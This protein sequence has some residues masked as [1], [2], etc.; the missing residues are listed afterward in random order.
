V[1]VSN[2]ANNNFQV[3][4]VTPSFITSTTENFTVGTECA[5]TFGKPVDSTVTIKATPL[6]T[7]T[8]T[9]S[10]TDSSTEVPETAETVTITKDCYG[11]CDTP[12]NPAMFMVPA[13]RTIDSVLIECSVE[14]KATG[15]VVEA[16]DK[17]IAFTKRKASNKY[18]VFVD[19]FNS[20]ITGTQHNVSVQV[21]RKNGRPLPAEQSVK[22]QYSFDSNV[23]DSTTA[24][25]HDLDAY[26]KTD[27]LIDIPATVNE[28]MNFRVRTEH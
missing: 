27:I 28:Y 7:S 21:L 14:E 1:E 25:T 2:A 18:D 4:V 9:T 8:A 12:V 5:Y 22:C 13:D 17:T 6:L 19:Y 24:T 15:S 11:T 3:A 10:T 26:G 20:V 23:T 16:K